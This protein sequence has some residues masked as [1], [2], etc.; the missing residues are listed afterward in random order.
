MT[1]PGIL[2]VFSKPLTSPSFTESAYNEWYTDHHIHH[3][4]EAGLCDLAIR[5]KNTNKEAKWPYVCIYRLPDLA[6]L[7]DEKVTGS[8]PVK[9]EL[10]P[11]GKPW[12]ELLDTDRKAF[13]LVQRFEGWRG[14]SGK[15]AGV[16]CDMSFHG[17][18][19]MTY[20]L[21]Y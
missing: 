16:S 19:R 21:E 3:I 17:A 14:E 6:K 13:K 10:L 5:Y 20:P 12:M 7:Q 1:T 8:I 2:V 9:H 4:V 11:D 18:A 15:L